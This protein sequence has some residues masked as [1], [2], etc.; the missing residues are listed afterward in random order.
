MI[1]N[2]SGTFYYI[3]KLRLDIFFLISHYTQ[4][5]PDRSFTIDYDNNT[6]LKDG[7]PFRYVSGSFHYSR[8]PA[9]YWQDRLDKMKMAGLNA[10]QT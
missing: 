4:A 1:K 9:F 2:I 8:V 6:F 7:Q 10:V 3:S 5:L